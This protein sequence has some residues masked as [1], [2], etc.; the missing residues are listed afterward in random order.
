[1]SRTFAYCPELPFIP[2]APGIGKVSASDES[3]LGR[4]VLVRG[5][6]DITP[7]GPGA[8]P[9]FEP[10]GQVSGADAEHPHASR[11]EPLPDRR[12][13]AGPAGPY[14]VIAKGSHWS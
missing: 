5:G 6:G 12:G 14:R 8:R 11:R 7:C 3:L 9:R 1:M 2:G 13:H 4:R 10:G